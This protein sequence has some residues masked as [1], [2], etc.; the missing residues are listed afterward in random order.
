[1][2]HLLTTHSSCR[3]GAP[4][5]RMVPHLLSA[6]PE[7]AGN[8]G[9]V[10]ETTGQ[11]IDDVLV[12]QPVILVQV[13][14]ERLVSCAGRG[15]SCQGCQAPW[16]PCPPTATGLGPHQGRTLASPAPRPRQ[17]VTC[18]SS[19]P[20]RGPHAA[21]S[22]ADWGH[23][24]RPSAKTQRSGQPSGGEGGGPPTPPGLPST[25]GTYIKVGVLAVQLLFIPSSTLLR[26]S[27][28]VP[29]PVI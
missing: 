15:P 27:P 16:S 17:T 13:L 26:P 6:Q 5:P 1:M 24:P 7:V 22:A 10:L 12:V 28:R 21:F 29:V 14:L 18:A 11:V 9:A 2:Q 23:S 19:C 25:H 3:G 4:Y 20:S 8:Y